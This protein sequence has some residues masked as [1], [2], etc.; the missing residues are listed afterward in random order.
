M[1]LTN[2][3]AT[4]LLEYLARRRTVFDLPLAPFGTDFDAAVRAYVLTIPYGQTRTFAEVA[5]AIGHSGAHRAV[6][7]AVAKNPLAVF[8]PAH[9]VVS[10]VERRNLEAVRDPAKKFL[11]KLEQTSGR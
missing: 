10:G 3:A 6:S 7:M 2:R 1:A 9:R 11:L 8:V 5:Q 4:E